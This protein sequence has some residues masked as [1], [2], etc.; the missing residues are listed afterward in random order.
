MPCPHV[1]RIPELARAEWFWQPWAAAATAT[2]GHPNNLL[3]TALREDAKQARE[4]SLLL[5]RSLLPVLD[6]AGFWITCVLESQRELSDTVQGKG[7]GA[8]GGCPVLSMH[9]K[10]GLWRARLGRM[11]DP[12]LLPSSSTSWGW[13]GTLRVGCAP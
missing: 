4:P 12:G 13:G 11:V 1:A 7:L 10:L 2:D 5:S 9:S 3:I 6:R 8:P